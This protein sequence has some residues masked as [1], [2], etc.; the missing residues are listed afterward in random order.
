MATLESGTG[1]SHLPAR[2]DVVVVGAGVNGLATAFELTKRG[3]RN[4]V[5]LERRF[6]GAG[7]SG[8]SGALVRQ[9]YTNVPEAL[10]TLHSLPTFL[11]W[12][13]TVGHGDPGFVQPGFLRVVAPSDEI[14]IRRN[15]DQLRAAGVN[16]WVVS[17]DEI[18]EIEPLMRTDD[19]S[20]AAFEPDAGYADPNAT[21]FGYAEAAIAGE[22]GSSRTARPFVWTRPVIESAV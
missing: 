22:H 19:L 5:V 18:R 10:L 20:V 13:D 15:V 11:N 6:I 17:V 14:N 1:T 16:T 8:K 12:G 21:M 7:A 9:H 3:V 4:V 2:A